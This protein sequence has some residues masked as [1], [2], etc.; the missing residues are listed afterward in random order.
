MTQRITLAALLRVDLPGH[1]VLLSDGGTVEVNG[2]SYVARDTLIGVPAGYESLNEGTADEAPAGLITFNLPAGSGAGTVNRKAFSG[3]R[4]RLFVAEVNGDTGQAVGTPD[5][6]ADWIVD[7]TAM[8]LGV[9]QRQ[10][11]V[12]FVS[13]GERLFQVNRGNALSPG[14]H[15]SIYANETGLDNA[16]GATLVDAWGAPSPPRG[17]VSSGIY[18]GNGGGGGGRFDVVQAL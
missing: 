12:A 18:G 15:K 1:V 17:T 5:Q 8:V 10:L 9:G 11:E 3:A 4:A 14:F 13:G 6:L 2:D 7:Q 16:T